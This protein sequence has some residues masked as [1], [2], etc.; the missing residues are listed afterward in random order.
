MEAFVVLVLLSL[1]TI[2]ITNIKSCIYIDTIVS[3]NVVIHTIH[4][5]CIIIIVH[6]SV[7]YSLTASVNIYPNTSVI[8][9]IKVC[10]NT[11]TNP[12]I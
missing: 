5:I 10:V 11:N 12:C 3:L 7:K 9:Y 6:D 2:L 1:Y 4:K 8:I